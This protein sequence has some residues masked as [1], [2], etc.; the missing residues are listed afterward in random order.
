MLNGKAKSSSMKMHEYTLQNF[1]R[2]IL[3]GT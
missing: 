2:D 1:C 3:T